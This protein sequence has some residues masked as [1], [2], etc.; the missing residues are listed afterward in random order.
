VFGQGSGLVDDAM[1]WVS[2]LTLGVPFIEDGSD[3]TIVCDGKGVQI[4]SNLYDALL[5]LRQSYPSGCWVDALCINQS[6]DDEKSIQIQMMGRIYENTQLVPVWFGTGWSMFMPGIRTIRHSGL[7]ARFEKSGTFW[8]LTDYSRTMMAV[9]YLV[10]R[11]WF[12]RLW[13]LQE[14]HLAKKLHFMV[15][16]QDLEPERIIEICKWLDDEDLDPEETLI[17][18]VFRLIGGQ[19]RPFTGLLKTNKDA[20]LQKTT[21]Y[22]WLHLAE[23][24][25]PTDKRDIVYAGLGIVDPDLLWINSALMEPSSSSTLPHAVPNS[26]S[27]AGNQTAAQDTKKVPRLWSQL[28]AKLEADEFEVHLNLAACIL[29]QS[30]PMNILSVSSGRNVE[31]AG[32]YPS[33]M[34]VPGKLNPL[35][36]E[37]LI[38][39]APPN[40]YTACT[41]LLGQSLISAD[42]HILYIYASEVNVVCQTWPLQGDD[43]IPLVRD[44]PNI[45]KPTGE[46]MLRVL[47]RVFTAGLWSDEICAAEEAHLRI[48]ALKTGTNYRKGVRDYEKVKRKYP[49]HVWPD[50]TSIKKSGNTPIRSKRRDPSSQSPRTT[51]ASTE[52]A[53]DEEATKFHWLR[54]RVTGARV[55]FMTSKGYV[56]IGSH[57]IKRSDSLVLVKGASVPHI[58]RLKGQEV[59]RTRIPWGLE[60]TDTLQDPMNGYRT[61]KDRY[62]NVGEA[63]VE[64]MMF[65]ELEMKARFRRIAVV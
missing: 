22:Q 7:Q 44:L 45:Y 49:G 46:S 19:I 58:F 1:S 6:D 5:R 23:M 59:K 4:T 54:R 9:L 39:I 48:I 63:Y 3:R 40:Y 25:I 31:N 14:A 15:G 20:K 17:R 33:W 57:R 24:R 32:R 51:N 61:E 34:P 16:D 38:H 60:P 10:T 42:A 21:V 55:A 18:D 30:G 2:Q 64:G 11:R 65:G 43:Y 37:L 47:A 12:N 35:K 8:L 26:P 56:G 28:G 53:L 62:A 52:G 41:N 29:S 13:V 27:Q 36:L 50:S